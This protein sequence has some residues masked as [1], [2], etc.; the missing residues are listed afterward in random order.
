MS[1]IR[2][3]KFA[4]A[5]LGGAEP[6]CRRAIGEDQCPILTHVRR[7]DRW[8]AVAQAH[9]RSSLLTAGYQP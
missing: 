3:P 7:G 2:I 1:N 9:E 6:F 5:A 8:I 4:I